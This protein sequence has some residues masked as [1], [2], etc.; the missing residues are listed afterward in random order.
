AVRIGMGDFLGREQSTSLPQNVDYGRI[1]FEDVHGR[2]EFG[3]FFELSS[4][5]HW[6]INVQAICLSRGIVFL[7]VTGSRVDASG[8]L[9]QS[10]VVSQYKQ[11]LAFEKRMFR[12]KPF[13]SPAFERCQYLAWTEAAFLG[14][15]LHQIRSHDVDLVSNLDC[16]VVEIGI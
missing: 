9:V 15:R 5:V 10:D 4:T 7:T 2:E 8:A 1:C 12:F 6:A 13:Q 16:R 3:S 14:R 11:R